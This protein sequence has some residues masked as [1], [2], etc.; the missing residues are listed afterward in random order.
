MMVR[1]RRVQQSPPPQRRGQSMLLMFLIILML[2]GVMALTL[3]F[4]FVLL[5][6]RQMQTGVNAAAVEGLRG[7]GL[8]GYGA[9]ERENARKLL[10][11][12]FDDDLDPD[13]GNAT[14]IGAGIDSSLI[15]RNDDTP[16]NLELG[17][18]LDSPTTGAYT[19]GPADTTL[20]EDLANRSSF[21]F[22]PDNFQLNLDDEPHG[23]M[24]VGQYVS[25]LNPN[26][27]PM[28]VDSPEHT[29]ISS[30]ERK[31]FRTAADGD[32]EPDDPPAFLVR[33][34]RTHNPDNLDEVSGVSSSGRGLP[35]LLG[36]GSFISA[37]PAGAEYSVRRDLSLI[38]I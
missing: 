2:L 38:H 7:H 36:R 31:D 23:D 20:A 32:Y 5:A 15:E 24:V 13:A 8:S 25:P 21:I 26:P 22:R 4:G 1:H 10:R 35:L 34:R 33:M 27:R 12:A 30:Y 17:D 9:E 16:E 3:D 6:R 14:T 19:I 29:E 28:F 37:E 18:G 11:N